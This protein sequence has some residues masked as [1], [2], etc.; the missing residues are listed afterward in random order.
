[1]AAAI[2]RP[3]DAAD[4]PNAAPIVHGN[5]AVAQSPI[6]SLETMCTVQFA[7]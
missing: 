5:N 4:S 3:D 1:M 7:G 2:N 6:A